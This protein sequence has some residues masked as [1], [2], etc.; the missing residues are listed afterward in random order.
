MHFC[1]SYKS[2]SRDGA[3]GLLIYIESVEDLTFDKKPCSLC[4]TD[5]LRGGGGG[6]NWWWRS[7]IHKVLCGFCGELLKAKMEVEVPASSAH[8]YTGDGNVFISDRTFGHMCM[9]RW[10]VVLFLFQESLSVHRA[11]FNTSQNKKYHIQI[12]CGICFFYVHGIC[13]KYRTLC[14]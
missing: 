10:R 3:F 2:G 12:W 11:L 6:W 4:L 9:K 13:W 7:K 5:K 14:G 8:A 1:F